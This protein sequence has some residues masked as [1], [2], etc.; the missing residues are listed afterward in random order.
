MRMASIAAAVGRGL[1]AGLAGTAA[2][3]ASSTIEAKVRERGASTTPAEAVEHAL[4]VE[5]TDETG[6]ERLNLASHWGYG[7]A[8]GTLRGA[9]GLAGL[10]GPRATLAHL[11]MVIAA[12]QTVLPGLKVSPPAWKW[13]PQEIATDLLHH[14][15]YALGAGLAYDRLVR[16]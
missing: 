8:L 7:T 4:H 14:S 11:G 2:M 12:E 1:M 6:E 9:L 15:V 16:R 5:P 3:T 13:P 10:R